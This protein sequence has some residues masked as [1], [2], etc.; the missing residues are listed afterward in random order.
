METFDVPGDERKDHSTTADHD[1]N[2]DPIFGAIARW[3]PVRAR[4]I[5]LTR[6]SGELATSSPNYKDAEAITEAMAALHERA[7]RDVYRAVPISPSGLIAMIE[8]FAEVEGVGT[9]GNREDTALATIFETTKK[10][11]ADV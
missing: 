4:L 6:I 9:L 2:T 7:L 8:V 5:E 11:L 3:L 1:S 10:M